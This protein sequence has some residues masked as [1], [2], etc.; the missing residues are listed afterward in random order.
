[1]LITFD[2]GYQDNH[3]TA[4]PVLRQHGAM[5]VFFVTTR[6]V[7]SRQNRLWLHEM[8]ALLASVDP[9]ALS[10]WAAARELTGEGQVEG[11]FADG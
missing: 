8:E 2:D 5:A 7:G 4:L 6:F 10:T 1:M 3:W 11:T 9:K